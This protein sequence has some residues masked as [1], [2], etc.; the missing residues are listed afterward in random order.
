MKPREWPEGLEFVRTEL[1]TGRTF[2]AIALSSSHR[3]K[4]AR[5]TANART[6]YDTALRH[7]AELRVPDNVST[8]LEN[9][10][11][12]LRGQLRQLGESF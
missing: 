11:E 7:L 8:E 10:F 12:A 4:I 5:N 1:E 6:A 2:A 9:R 3:D